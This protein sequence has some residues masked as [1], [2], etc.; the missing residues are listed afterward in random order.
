MRI[1]FQ[2]EVTI[3]AELEGLVTQEEMA[4]LKQSSHRWVIQAVKKILI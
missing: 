1:H 4:M 2:P 3:E